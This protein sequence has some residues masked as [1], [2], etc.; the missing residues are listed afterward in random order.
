MIEI[1]MWIFVGLFLS[2]VFIGF[3]LWVI[4]FDTGVGYAN[5][6]FEDYNILFIFFWLPAS[7]NERIQEVISK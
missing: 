2:Y 1:L 3:L 6:G 4:P 7:F 5:C